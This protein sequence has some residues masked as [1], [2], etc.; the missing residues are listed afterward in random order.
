MLL[1]EDTFFGVFKPMKVEE[2][3]DVFDH[4][5]VLPMKGIFF[6]LLKSTIYNIFWSNFIVLL[7]VPA[8]PS[9]LH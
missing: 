8:E 7:L 2:D 3:R 6:F 5:S 1:L 9:S 4:H